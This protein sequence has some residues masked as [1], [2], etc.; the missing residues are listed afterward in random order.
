MTT[1]RRFAREM[2]IDWNGVEYEIEERF[3]SGRLRLLNKL[4]LERREVAEAQLVDDLFDGSLKMLGIDNEERTLEI[5]IEHSRVQDFTSLDDDDPK[6]IDAKKRLTY[7][8][9]IFAENGKQVS[10]TQIASAIGSISKV[11][12]D[13][14]SPTVRTVRRWI[15]KYLASGEDIRALISCHKAK[16]NRVRKF[17]PDK[18]NNDKVLSVINQGINEIYLTPQRNSLQAVADFVENE[19]NKINETRDPH[20]HLPVPSRKSIGRIIS[21]LD[22]YERDLTRMGKKYALAKHKVLH[23]GVRPTRPLERVECDDTKTDM[24]VV[25]PA[26]WLPLGRP[27]LMVLICV[28]TKM[29]LGYFLSFYPPS[30]VT[31][32]MAVKHAIRPKSYL[33]EKYPEI[34]NSW[35]TYGLFE[36]LVIDNAKHWY[37]KGLDDAFY[38]AGIELQYCPVEIPWYKTSIERLLKTITKSLVQKLPGT[39]FSNILEKADYDPEKHALITLDLLEEVLHKWIVDVY[40]QDIHRGINDIPSRRWREGIVKYPP[41]LPPSHTDLNVIFGKIEYRTISGTV[42]RFK[43]LEYSDSALAA[44]RNGKKDGSRTKIK[45]DPTNLGMIYV[46]DAFHHRF[47]PV[48]AVDQEYAAGLTEWQHEVICKFARSRNQSLINRKALMEA[49]EYIR[50]RIIEAMGQKP[51]NLRGIAKVQKWLT[52]EDP[53]EPRFLPRSSKSDIQNKQLQSDVVQVPEDD[54]EH[55]DVIDTPLDWSDGETWEAIH[56]EEEDTDA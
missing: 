48:P 53:S 16:G 45:Y 44:I 22:P 34:V 41:A 54:M 14:N 37:G 4:S 47:I 46:F 43:N 9:G 35:D 21:K 3:Q 55:I 12:D 6:K 8:K 18:E 50:Q 23:K 36:T 30:H 31:V 52:F 40:S 10:D 27:W 5:V 15:E 56:A 1:G 26:T 28:Y 17:C 39:T 24:L 2:K 13:P 7:L 19:I 29:I 38:Q 49:K 42:I 11:I 25:D 51:K 33:R 32:M 20:D